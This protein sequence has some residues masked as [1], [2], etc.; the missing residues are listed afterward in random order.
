MALTETGGQPWW[1]SL[2]WQEMGGAFGDIGTFAPLAVTLIQVNHLNPTVVFAL[3]GALYVWSGWYYRLP[4]PVQP[5]KSFTV[6]AIALGL[7]PP[8][9]GAGGVL[10]GASLL[11]IAASG[12]ADRLNR[13]FT[14][15]LV[16]GIQMGIGLILIA[17]GLKMAFTP[18]VPDLHSVLVRGGIHPFPVGLVL[19]GLTLVLLIGFSRSA[20]FPVGL[21]IV[22]FGLVAGL[23]LNAIPHLELGIVVPA[24]ALP[25][26]ADLRAALVLLVLPQL[27]LTLTNSVVAMR[28]VARTYF[29]D[30]ARHVTHRA[31]CADLGVANVASGILMGM[32]MCHGSGG[33]TAHYRLGARTGGS[34][35]FI[36]LLLLV[37]GLVFGPS[38]A[39]ICRLIPAPV[40]GVLL[41]YVGVSHALLVRDVRGV[42]DWGVVLSMG[43]VSGYFKHNGY[44][45]LVGAAFYFFRWAWVRLSV[46]LRRS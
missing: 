11:L 39:A 43:L 15:P 30:E 42:F 45:L 20:S 7:P 37:I 21:V 26:I 36:G 3:A 10:M 14:R 34:M 18:L 2:P 27:P 22:G 5:L 17:S 29:G 23:L 35:I 25:R 8:V 40:L 1:K 16:R 4:V 41:A 13:V 24:F 19:A 44:G 9:V 33:M 46:W 28:D 6:L 32:P 38:T 31:L 12:L